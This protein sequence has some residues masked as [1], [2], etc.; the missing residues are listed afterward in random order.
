MVILNLINHT[1]TRSTSKVFRD[2]IHW[3]SLS[4]ANPNG[5][6]FIIDC[7]TFVT[8]GILFHSAN[9]LDRPAPCSRAKISSSNTYLRED[10]TYLRN[11]KLMVCPSK[12]PLK[13]FTHVLLRAM[14]NIS[15]LLYPDKSIETDT[16]NSQLMNG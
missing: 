6:F 3:L 15:Y 9:N 16:C 13:N 11:T 2:L 8:C 10:G 5:F 12:L 1:F 4:H 14:K 7:E